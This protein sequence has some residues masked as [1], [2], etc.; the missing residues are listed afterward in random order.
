MSE[1][2]EAA[3]ALAGLVG[4]APEDAAESAFV[5]AEGAFRLPP[6]AEHP[7][8]PAAFGLGSEPPDHLVAVLP[9]RLC[10]VTAAI[11]RDDGRADAQFLPG[12]TRGGTRNRTRRRPAARSHAMAR[13]AWARTGR[14]CGESLVG[15]VVTVAPAIKWLAVSQA[16]VSL[17]Q[18]RAVIV[19]PDAA[20]RSTGRRAGCLTRWHRPRRSAARRSGCTRLRTWWRSGGG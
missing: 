17:V 6:L 2:A 3:F 1:D 8:R 20:R 16:V 13:D 11:D 19:P 4:L 9:A 10:G 12:H 7:L 15:P 18:V 5:P 14:N